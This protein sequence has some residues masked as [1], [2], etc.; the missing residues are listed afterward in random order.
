LR[1]RFLFI[2][3]FFTLLI[4]L[5]G[6]SGSDSGNYLSTPAERFQ[7]SVDT[8]WMQYKQTHALPEGGV[9]VYVE[10]PSGSYFA[11]SG[12]P[13]GVNQNTHFRAGSNT[14]T[15]TAAAIM[16]LNQLG[17]LN[18][19]DFITSNIP[20]KG[21]PYVPAT[22]AYNIPN[23]AS[24]TIRQ[25]LSHTAGVF[26]ISNQEVPSTCTCTYA[27]QSY[28]SSVY[29]TDPKHQF[30]ADELVGVI[31]AC[32]ISY[33]TP[34]G[35]YHYSNAGYWILS[36]I[37]ERVSGMSYD[38]FVMNNLIT[39]NGLSST[40]IPMLGTDQAIRAPFTPGY[41]YDGSAMTDATLAN[42]SP[43]VGSGNII[44]TPADLARW[45]RRLI[46][47]EAGLSAASVAVMKTA[48]PQSGSNKYGL[49]IFCVDRLGYGHNGAV[50][51]YLSQMLYDPDS[52]VTTI[53]YFNVW[54][55]PHLNPDQFALNVK[56]AQDAKAAL[57]Y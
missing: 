2:L 47:A 18:I 9:A 39:P 43:S 46:R 8:N 57:G 5:T 29:A 40:T 1:I 37:I 50:S 7:A 17:S 21:V 4:L 48:T 20:V 53:V 44:S 30:S 11:S 54:D 23:K 12:M 22:A 38:Q 31:A 55:V 26:D 32:Q 28:I 45:V 16:L 56:I 15:F 34:G 36:T 3:L 6:C 52:D 10:T 19:D 14:K 27:G 33:F 25:L 42:Q 49:G 35:G 41:V 13:A 24:I 51:G